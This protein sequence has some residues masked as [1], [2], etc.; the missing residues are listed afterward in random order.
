[1]M[2]LQNVSR[3]T[4]QSPAPLPKPHGQITR[5]DFLKLLIAQ[6]Q[7]QDPLSPMDNQEFAVQ[8]A[9]F[10]SLEQLIGVNEKLDSLQ[11]KQLLASQLNSAALLGKQVIS[12]GKQITLAAENDATVRYQLS[13]NAA[14][15][16][17]N[18]EDSRGDLVRQL[19]VGSQTA[20]D[21]LLRW[22]GKDKTGN[23]AP[24]GVY[25]VSLNA[26]DAAGKKVEAKTLIQG[27]VTGISLDGG[28]AVLELGQLKIPMSA[29][30]GI[31]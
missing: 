26:F 7:N 14:K 21:Q 29:V 18:I 28:S 17:I 8:L 5:D 19:N 15:V 2:D 10:N 1:M 11:S 9:T 12:E 20:G 3:T 6:L 4:S 16:V 31:R 23:R 25:T 13:A 24:A 27:P 22:D 30:I